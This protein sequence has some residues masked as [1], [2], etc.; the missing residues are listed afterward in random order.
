MI[1]NGASTR[2]DQPILEIGI[3]TKGK[4]TLSMVL[5][6]LLLQELQNIRIHIVDTSETPV[7]KRDDVMFALKLAFD[8]H[9]ACGYEYLRE[10]DRAFSTGRL[11]LL[12]ALTGRNICFMDDDVVMPSDT[13]AKIA[14]FVQDAGEY[15]YYAPFCRNT[16]ARSLASE[17]HQFSPGTIFFQD[18][19]VRNVLLEYYETTVDVLDKKRSREKVWEIAFLSRLFPLLGRRCVVQNDNVIYHLDYH[20]R[21]KW[22]LLEPQLVRSSTTMARDLVRKHAPAV[23]APGG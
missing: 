5:V 4:P 18:E 23:V 16:G 2:S 22:D 1:S 20:E 14:S 3:L 8:R 13:L 10:K 21:P 17:E 12:E 9:I 15:G 19:L 6:S 7:I 11:K